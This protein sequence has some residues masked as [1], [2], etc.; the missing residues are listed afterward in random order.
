MDKGLICSRVHCYLSID[1]PVKVPTMFDLIA[2]STHGRS[3][4]SRWA[5]GSVTDKVLRR[6]G[7]VPIV[8]VKAPKEAEKA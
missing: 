2:M 8:M 5:F 4:L 3:G 6:G 7:T 1:N